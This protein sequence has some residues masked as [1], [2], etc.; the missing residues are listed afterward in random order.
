MFDICLVFWKS[1]PQYAY[2]RYVHRENMYLFLK[3]NHSSFSLPIE[4]LVARSQMYKRFRSIFSC[5]DICLGKLLL[6]SRYL[7]SATWPD[8][9][10]LTA[11]WRSFINMMNNQEI[12]KNAFT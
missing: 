2:K 6:L 9:L 4:I 3:D 5:C 11:L 8:W 1:E 12:Q 7:S 10:Y